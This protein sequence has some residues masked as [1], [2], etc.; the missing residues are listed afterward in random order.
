MKMENAISV[1]QIFLSV[2]Y[3]GRNSVKNYSV[4]VNI[5]VETVVQNYITVYTT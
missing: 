5:G 1:L 4:S 2:V 3:I